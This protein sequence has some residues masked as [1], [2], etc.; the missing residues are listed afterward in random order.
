[1]KLALFSLNILGPSEVGVRVTTDT[2]GNTG[3]VLQHLP[4]QVPAGGWLN[5]SGMINTC[6]IVNIIFII[7]LV[8]FLLGCLPS[9]LHGA[10]PWGGTI[11]S[12][13]S[14]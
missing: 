10:L 7:E 4:S 3:A 13:N 9:I 14:P 11:S 2:R 8:S 1:M 6:Y 5:G 12:I